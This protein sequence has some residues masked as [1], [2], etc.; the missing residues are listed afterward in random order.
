MC[1]LSLGLNSLRFSKTAWTLSR[2]WSLCKTGEYRGIAAEFKPFTDTWKLFKSNNTVISY[3]S[4][5]SMRPYLFSVWGRKKQQTENLDSHGCLSAVAVCVCVEWV[6]D[7]GRHQHPFLE[8][9][10]SDQPVRFLGPVSNSGCPQGCLL[11]GEDHQSVFP[12]QQPQ[13]GQELQTHSL[14]GGM[15]CQGRPFF[16]L[17]SYSTFIYSKTIKALLCCA[18][19]IDWNALIMFCRPAFSYS[20]L[21]FPDFIGIT[22]LRCILHTFF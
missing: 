10:V 12:Q 21:S 22:A 3:M 20:S 8:E 5:A 14:W 9:H 2:T 1:A 17:T 19:Q 15:D 16:T 7:V 18:Y 6:R 13:P 11:P 4:P